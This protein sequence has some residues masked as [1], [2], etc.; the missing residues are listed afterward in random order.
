M[1]KFLSAVTMFV[2]MVAGLAM[3]LSSRFIPVYV[4]GE[5]VLANRIMRYVLYVIILG[6]ILYSFA[7]TISPSKK[8]SKRRPR[9]R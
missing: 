2:A 5:Y 6:I 1:K 3:Y 4:N 8:H 7:Y 9:R